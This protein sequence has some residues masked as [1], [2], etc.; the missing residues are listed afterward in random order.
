M[1]QF[2][3]TTGLL[4]LMSLPTFAGNV[5]DTTASK[6]TVAHVD[7][8]AAPDALFAAEFAQVAANLKEAENFKAELMNFERKVTAAGQNTWSAR[9][10]E[11]DDVVLAVSYAVWWAM[12]QPADVMN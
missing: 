7:D 6:V 4:L 5:K 9:G 12:S 10:S 3:N 1:K 11:S 2:I 8:N